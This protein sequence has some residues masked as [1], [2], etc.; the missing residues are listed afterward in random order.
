MVAGGNMELTQQRY[1][2]TYVVLEDVSTVWG[3]EGF[4]ASTEI[5]FVGT[6]SHC[7]DWI[8]ANPS[9]GNAY[10]MITLKQYDEQYED[11]PETKDEETL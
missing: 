1:A 4:D 11:T 3:F 9:D 5:L 6:R 8:H 10:R 7:T 2:H